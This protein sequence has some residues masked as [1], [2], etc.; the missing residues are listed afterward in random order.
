MRTQTCLLCGQEY[1]VDRRYRH[2]GLCPAC[3]TPALHK[4]LVRWRTQID[5]TRRAGHAADLTFP[6]WL[7]TLDAFGWRCAYCGKRSTGLVLEHF[8]PMCAGGTTSADNCVSA[9]RSCNATKDNRLPSNCGLPTEQI[10][11]VRAYL[12]VQHD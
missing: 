12:E 8:V 5:R 6:Q 9:C 10:A 1:P 11:K 2:D 3:Q 7:A 4:E